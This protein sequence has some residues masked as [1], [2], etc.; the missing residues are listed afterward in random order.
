VNNWGHF[1]TVS[2]LQSQFPEITFRRESFAEV[3][4]NLEEEFTNTF[5][6]FTKIN[7][8]ICLFSPPFTFD[9]KKVPEPLQLELID[10]QCDDVMKGVF[11]P[12][13]LLAFYKSLPEEKYP[14]LKK[15]AQHLVSMFASTYICEQTFSRMKIQKS[16]LR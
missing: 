8:D 10:M 9:V 16:R 1:P 5:A 12:S 6:D 13:N 4:E 14:L 7:A 15:Q 3:I 2:N 11:D